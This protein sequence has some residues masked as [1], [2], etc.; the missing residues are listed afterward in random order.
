VTRPLSDKPAAV[1]M[2]RHR[3]RERRGAQLVGGEVG[4]DLLSGLVDLGALAMSEIEDGD[5]IWRAIVDITARAVEEAM[6]NSRDRKGGGAPM[7]CC[8]GRPGRG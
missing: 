1:R 5:A 3:E 6:A 4:P 8:L 7:R 2:R